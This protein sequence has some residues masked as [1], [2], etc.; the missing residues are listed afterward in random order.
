MD[1]KNNNITVKEI[2][3]NPKA[4]NLLQREFPM[5]MNPR[6]LQLV[7]NTSLQ[8]VLEFGKTYVSQAKINHILVELKKI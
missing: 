8:V 6:F 4:R 3:A 2:L 1:L 5:V 7:Q